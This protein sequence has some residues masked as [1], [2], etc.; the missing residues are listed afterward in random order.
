MFWCK[1][2][3]C[4]K[5][6]QLKIHDLQIVAQLLLQFI[7]YCVTFVQQ[8]TSTCLP[9]R[10]TSEL[11]LFE[12]FLN[13]HF[14]GACFDCSKFGQLKVHDLQI[15]MFTYLHTTLPQPSPTTTAYKTLCNPTPP[16][17]PPKPKA[18]AKQWEKADKKKPL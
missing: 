16:P 18:K 1:F 6:G 9:P 2:Q 12:L 5:F 15:V 4:S 11:A 14:F 3:N 13:L 7:E 8:I 17:M 10:A